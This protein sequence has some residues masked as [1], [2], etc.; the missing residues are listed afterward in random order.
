MARAQIPTPDAL[1]VQLRPRFE[2]VAPSPPGEVLARL[3]TALG[4]PGAPCRGHV[5]SGH[6]VLHVLQ[7]EERVWSPFLSLDVEW[8]PE[9]TRIRG[10]FGP[11]P[12]IWSLFVASYAFCL[13]SALGAAGFA[14]AQWTIQQPPSALI[15]LAAATV[16]ALLTWGFARYGQHLG[17]GQMN[18]LR[19]FLDEVL[20]RERSVAQR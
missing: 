10:L 15:G 20:E 4:E 12:A 5:F 3:R 9:G 19:G 2:C 17:R 11:K 1:P 18:L 14:Y 16:V 6:A 13:F 7:T 8:H